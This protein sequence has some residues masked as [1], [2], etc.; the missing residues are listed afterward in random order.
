MAEYFLSTGPYEDMLG[1]FDDQK[2]AVG[3]GK[4]GLSGGHF[5][6]MRQIHVGKRI[7]SK[8]GMVET[9]YEC[10]LVPG[11]PTELVIALLPP[12][13]VIGIGIARLDPLMAAGAFLL[14]A[15]NVVSINIASTLT[16][17]LKGVRPAHGYYKHQ[18]TQQ[19]KGRLVIWSILLVLI[20][21]AM[22]VH[23]LLGA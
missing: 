21:V 10:M 9:F 11:D 16:F 1:P 5:R 6:A 14:L 8:E 2:S 3:R 12:A 17:V 4:A 23:R 19:V 7:A 13:A 18:A 22:G 15:I 20:L